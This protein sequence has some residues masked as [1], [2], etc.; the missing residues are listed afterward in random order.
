[1]AYRNYGLFLKEQSNARRMNEDVYGSEGWVLI[2][3]L[4]AS[5]RYNLE[6]M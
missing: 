6:L 4:V 5:D 2:K 3:I 1:M